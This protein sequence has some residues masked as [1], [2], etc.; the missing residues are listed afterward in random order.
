MAAVIARTAAASSRP[1]TVSV[2]SVSAFGKVLM[3]TSVM[4]ASVPNEP[5]S[6]LQRS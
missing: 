6:S 1:S 4:A 5:A 2:A 3:V